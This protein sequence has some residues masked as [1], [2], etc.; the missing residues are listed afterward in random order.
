MAVLGLDHV[1]VRS[2]D[3]AA[4]VAFFA[5]VLG[6]RVGPP[7]GQAEMAGA[8]GWIYDTEDRPVLHVGGVD[9]R[10]PTDAERPFEPAHGGGAVHH[11]ALSC[12]DYDGTKAR[13][14]AKELSFSENDFPQYGLKQLFVAEPNGILL[15][16]NFLVA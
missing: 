5:E 6:M 4:T 11:V 14:R 16:L 7:M 13:L 9:M 3:P 1:N 2:T 8:G 12:S 10:Y 15:E